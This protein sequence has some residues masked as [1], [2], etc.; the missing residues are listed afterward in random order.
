M[1][2][3]IT[4]Y[5]YDEI[6]GQNVYG[7]MPDEKDAKKLKEIVRLYKSLSKNSKQYLDVRLEIIGADSDR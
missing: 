2:E 4:R 1:S 7:I 6:L 3:D 5:F